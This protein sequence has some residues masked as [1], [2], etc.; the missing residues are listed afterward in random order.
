MIAG[1]VVCEGE[2]EALDMAK[3]LEEEDD[4][5][6]LVLPRDPRDPFEPWLLALFG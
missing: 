3:L 4:L 6:L 5:L 1:L 2:E